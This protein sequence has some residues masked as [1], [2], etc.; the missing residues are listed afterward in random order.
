MSARG[1]EGDTR[2]PQLH[3]VVG[4]RSTRRSLIALWSRLSGFERAVVA[5]FILVLIITVLGPWL[6][7]YPPTFA[8]PLQRLVP[9]MVPIRLGPMKTGLMSSQG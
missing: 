7:P 6:A 9:P 4:D 2:E 1:L 5:M 8:D 3:S